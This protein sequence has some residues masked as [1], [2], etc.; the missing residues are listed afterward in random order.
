MDQGFMVLGA[1][2]EMGA[3]VAPGTELRPQPTQELSVLVIG[4][5]YAAPCMAQRLP[6]RNSFG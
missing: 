3:V 2:A 5:P 4:K 1:W 6:F